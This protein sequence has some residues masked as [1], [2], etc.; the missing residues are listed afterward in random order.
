VT[1]ALEKLVNGNTDV[2]IDSNTD[3]GVGGRGGG[4]GGSGGGVVSDDVF[5]SEFGAPKSELS[6]LVATG[7]VSIPKMMALIRRVEDE[8]RQRRRRRRRRLGQRDGDGEGSDVVGDDGDVDNDGLLLQLPP[9]VVDPTPFL[10]T[11]TMHTMATI[12]A[13]ALL[14][15][16]LVRPVANRFH[17][18]RAAEQTAR[19]M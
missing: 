11:S 17:M 15:N 6:A 16:A 9:R 18:R 1:D 13:F 12:L 8:E 4:S 5:T 7:T 10:L 14:S 2:D 19:K 3:G